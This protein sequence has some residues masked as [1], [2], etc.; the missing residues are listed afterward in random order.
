MTSSPE[1]RRAPA[2]RFAA[3]DARVRAAVEEMAADDPNPADPFRGLYVSDGKAVALARA[4]GEVDVDERLAAVAA[5]LGLDALDAAALGLVAAPE[6]DPRHGRLFAYLHDDISRKLGTPRLVAR[7]LAGEGVGI[8]DVLGAFA[9]EGALRRLGVVALSEADPL[10]PLADR[11]VRVAPAVVAALI[12]ADLAPESPLEARLRRA[13]SPVRAEGRERPAA[14]LARVLAA[15]GR[16]PVVVAGPDAA[17]LAALA[18]GRPLLMV[19]LAD[20]RDAEL[21]AHATL[22]AALEGRALCLDRPEGVEPPD[23]RAVERGLADWPGRPLVLAA[24]ARAAAALDEATTLIVE[25]EPASLAERREAWARLAGV[26][27]ADDLEDVAAA[28][29]L[30]AGQVAEAAEV[31]GLLAA[32]R[33]DA[34]PSRADLRAGARRASGGRLG[35]L[36]TRLEPAWAWDDLVLPE[37]QTGQLRSVSAYLRHRDRVLGEWGYGG[38]HRGLGLKVLFAGES[39]TGKTMA[40]QVLAREIGLELYRIDLATMVSK[41]IGETE[42]NLDRVFAA[43]EGSNAILFFDEA[44]ALFGKRS[45]VRDAHDRYANIEVAYLLQRLETYSGAVI[46]AT[47]L[48]HNLDDAFLRRLDVAVD[49]PFPEPEDR[50]R[51]WTRALPDRAPVADDVDLAFLAE[52]FKLSGGGIRNASLA[53]AFLAAEGAGVI[54][55]PELVRAVAQEYAKLGRLTLESDFER[56]HGLVS[57]N[58]AGAPS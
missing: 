47:N 29:R 19:E 11:A 35:E 27:E 9:R 31:A 6:L 25:A 28:F 3:L 51:I 4:G 2:I 14:E 33:G 10:A 15:P 32:A 7:L 42:K 22:V 23:W 37:R 36:A 48:R 5:R 8:A 45:E 12:G 40:A 44:D 58:G 43:A 39:G 38:A 53:A 13:E 46:L 26:E 57:A 1:G 30:T 17:A 24:S 52:R 55:M 20:L 56:F 16:L 50:L 54:G 49:F 18:L 41:Y 21:L 34:R